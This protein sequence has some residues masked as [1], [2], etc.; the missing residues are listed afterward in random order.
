MLGRARL[1]LMLAGV[2]V[3]LFGTPAAA[4]EMSRYCQDAAA[5]VVIYIDKTTPY[6]EIDKKALVDGIGRLFESL[7][8]GERFTMRT[9]A[10]SFT[11]S[12]TLIDECIPACTCSGLLCDL[13]SECT[14]GMVINDRKK[15]RET[16]VLQLRALLDNFVELPNSEIVR[17]I[18]LSTPAELRAN[19]ENRLYLFTDL[20][21]NS[22]YLPGKQFFSEP[23]AEL[24]DQVESDGL[25]PDLANATVRVFGVGRG[26][27]T[28]RRPLD[29]EVLQKLLGFWQGY[30][31]AAHTSVTIQQSLGEV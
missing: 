2:C 10:E 4:G 31:D 24:L 19:T 29:Q 14:E 1:S 7:E 8:G 20:I 5:N 27:T 16:V 25:V 26:G 11:N 3:A 13:F 9:I 12:A 15:L 30:F 6:D 21:E 22:L 17:T 23:N 28:E 18:G